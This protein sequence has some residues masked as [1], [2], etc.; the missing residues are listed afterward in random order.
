MEEQINGGLE[1]LGIACEKAGSSLNKVIKTNIMLTD[2]N[3][4]STMR[5]LETEFYRQNAPDLITNPPVCTY[6]EV[7]SIENADTVF[8]IDAIGVM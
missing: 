1:K 6:M 3:N 7:E 8:Q 2:T 5:R 4:Y